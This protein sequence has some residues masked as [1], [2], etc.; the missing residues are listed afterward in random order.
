MVGGGEGGAVDGEEGG[1]SRAGDGEGKKGLSSTGWAVKEDTSGWAE[2][3][4][5]D[6]RQEIQK[7]LVQY[8]LIFKIL[9]RKLNL[10]LKSREIMLQ[11]I[12]RNL[13]WL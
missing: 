4:K 3:C 10:R 11:Q 6:D 1:P 9:K 2:T 7:Y 12:T 5:I 8:L 13:M